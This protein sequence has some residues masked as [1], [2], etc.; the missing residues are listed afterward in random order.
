MRTQ[1]YAHAHA[2]AHAHSLANA[3]PTVS[4]YNTICVVL[5]IL[6]T[7]ICNKL[8]TDLQIGHNQLCP[9]PKNPCPRSFLSLPCYSGEQWKDEITSAFTGLIQLKNNLPELSEDEVA[10]MVTNC[11]FTFIYLHVY[12]HFLLFQPSKFYWNVIKHVGTSEFKNV[13]IEEILMTNEGMYLRYWQFSST[14][15]SSMGG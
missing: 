2:H 1:A 6:D 12:L 5:N 11:L 15:L 3:M 4:F 10:D 13:I 9:W 14:S 7:E 8:Q